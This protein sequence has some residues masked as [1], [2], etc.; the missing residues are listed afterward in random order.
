VDYVG[1]QGGEHRRWNV[2][3][4]R[5]LLHGFDAIRDVVEGLEARG[6]PNRHYHWMAIGDRDGETQLFFNAADPYSSSL[7][8]AGPSAYNEA[9]VHRLLRI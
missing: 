1:V 5:L 9:G 6:R 7:Y 4:D 3:G 2:F 8:S